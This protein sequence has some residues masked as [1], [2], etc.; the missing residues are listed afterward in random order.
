MKMGKD[1]K[2]VLLDS[3]VIIHLFKAGRLSLLQ[4]LYPD[5]V[6]ILDVVYLELLENPTINNHIENL[7]R[8]KLAK[9]YDFPTQNDEVMNEYISLTQSQLKG[10]GE[11]ACMAVCR[12]DKNI[13]A[14]SN[15]RDIK[16]Y[17]AQHSIQYLTTL[18]LLAI[19]FQR[20]VITEADADQCIKDIKA[21]GSR[22][23]HYTSI[24]TF[25]SQEFDRDKLQY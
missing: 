7:V 14:S 18:D 23:P 24:L 2:L 4:E 12:F 16:P 20:Q 9:I 11:S 3:D 15:L 21:K 13:L 1:E 5:R 17:C 19:A 8:F 22:L 6:I 10:K 25:V